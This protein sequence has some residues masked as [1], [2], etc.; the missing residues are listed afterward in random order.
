M[1]AQIGLCS[2]KDVKKILLFPYPTVRVG[3]PTTKGRHQ[4][5]PSHAISKGFICPCMGLDVHAGTKS[6]EL[7][8]VG[9]YKYI[10]QREEGSTWAQVQKQIALVSSNGSL[11]L[12]GGIIKRKPKARW[13]GELPN[14]VRE[15]IFHRSL[16]Q[17]NSW[18]KGRQASP[19]LL[20][21]LGY[22]QLYYLISQHTGSQGTD[23]SAPG[24]EQREHSSLTFSKRAF[25]PYIF[26]GSIRPLQDQCK[27]KTQKDK[28]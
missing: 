18:A 14:M 28:H 3:T 7:S 15:G 23:G 22:L 10:E 13:W 11:Q 9:V 20:A 2:S 6:P 8:R 25:A 1:G 16:D 19:S 17:R 27:S 12:L 21:N 4:Q 24:K 26:K 5:T